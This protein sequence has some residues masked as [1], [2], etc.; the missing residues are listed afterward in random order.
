MLAE[1]VGQSRRRGFGQ[2]AGLRIPI[3]GPAMLMELDPPLDRSDR[4]QILV[5]LELV[6]ASQAAAQPASVLQHE[7]EQMLVLAASAGAL[8]SAPNSRSYTSRGLI[9]LATGR[10]GLCQEMCEP[11]SRVYPTLLSTPEMT[12]SVPSSSDGSG[13][14]LPTC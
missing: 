8:P 10:V 1:I 7:I 14:W 5:E 11:Y 12:G 3:V 2:T 13:V 6:V 4:I 9:S